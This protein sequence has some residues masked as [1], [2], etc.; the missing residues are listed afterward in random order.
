MKKKTKPIITKQ[1]TNV[2]CPCNGTN[3]KCRMCDGSGYYVDY[4]YIIEVNGRAYSADTL[5]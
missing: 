1:C 5:A 2:Q 3:P 4:H